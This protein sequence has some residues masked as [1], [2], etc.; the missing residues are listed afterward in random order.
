[1]KPLRRSALREIR[2][3]LGRYLAIFAIVALGVG[4]F[5]GLRVCRDAMIKTGDDYLS[6]QRM[7]DYRLIS[8]LGFSREDPSAFEALEGVV[9]AEGSVVKDALF[10]IGGAPVGVLKAHSLPERLNL[11]SLVEGRMPE[12]PGE[13][14]ADAK[15]F[16][17][18]AVGTV[19][20]LSPDNDEDTLDMFAGREYTIV[21]IGNSPLY[22]NFERGGTSLGSGTVAGFVYLPLEGFD[23]DYFTE[24]CV[25]CDA[26]GAIYSDVYSQTVAAYEDAVAD[27]GEERAQARYGKIVSDAESEL[28]EGQAEYDEGLSEYLE[29]R[30]DAE[31]ELGEALDKLVDGEGEIAENEQKLAD[32][33]AELEDAR[34]EL[35]SGK[36]ELSSSQQ[37][38]EGAER[39]A[40]AQLDQARAELE[41]NLSAAQDGMLQIEESGV[42]EQ[43]ALL[44]E[45]EVAL[46]AGIQAL[47]DARA[48]ILGAGDAFRDG[49]AQAQA[50]IDALTAQRDSA[51]AEPQSQRDTAAGELAAFE[52]ELSG[53]APGDDARIA[54]LEELLSW[55]RGEKARIEG[56]ISSAE[57]DFLARI[58][59]A[60]AEKAALEAGVSQA[61][62]NIESLKSA[63]DEAVGALEGEL[64]SVNSE[65][66]GAESELSGLDP[67]ADAGRIAELQ[68]RVSALSSRKSAL[69]GQISAVKSDYEARIA[70]AEAER[71]ALEGQVSQAAAGVESLQSERDGA[72]GAL[73]SELSGVEGEIA[74]AEG[75]LS[76]LSPSPD[77]GRFAEL[78][79]Q[80]S[81]K[82]QQLDTLDAQIAAIRTEYDARISEAE[83]AK[84]G[85]ES[86]LAEHEAALDANLGGIDAELLVLTGQLAQ[87][88]DGLSQ[89]E[90]GGYVAQ[91]AELRDA[92]PQIEAGLAEVASQ[93]AAAESQFAAAWREL[94]N[95]RAE[96]ADALVQIQDAEQELEDG[97]AQLEDARAELSDGYTEYA[98]AKAE[99]DAEFADAER[100]LEDA[101][102]ELQDAREKIDEIE[103]PDV[104]AL[105]RTANVGYM[106]FESDAQIVEGISE[107]FPLFF[108]MVAALVCMTTMTR[109]VDE[110]RTQIG[111]L[112]ALGYSPGAIMWKYVFYSGSAATLGS[113]VGFFAGSA[114]F[115]KVIWMAYGIMYGFSE[116]KL[117]YDWGLGAASLMAALLC[118]VGATWFSVRRD[119]ALTPAELIR[120]QAPKAG[121]RIFLEYVRPVWRRLK[122]LQKV[123]L[124]NIF[125]YKKRLAMMI[126]G[127]GGCTA[128]LV[129]GLG[130]RDSISDVVNYQYEEITRY[131]IAVEFIQAQDA[132]GRAAFLEESGAECLFV[133]EG[134]ADA[135]L[136][137]V[138]KSVNLISTDAGDISQFVDLHAGEERVALPGSNEAVISRGLKELTGADVGS[139]ITVRDGEMKEMR[140][141]VSGV[142]D[143]YV[144][145]YVYV[146][147]DT[148]L[149]QWGYAPDVKTA[150]VNVPEGADLHEMAARIAGLGD[151]G[152][153]SVNLDTQKRIGGMMENLNYI[154]MLIVF[155]AGALAFIVLYNLTN[156]NITERT[157]EIATIKVLGFF[158]KEAASYV[159]SE[160]LLLCMMS[161]LAGLP[162]GKWLHAFVMSQIRI[163]MMHFDVRVAAPSYLLAIA[164]TFA[165]AGMVNFALRFKL[166]RIN[167]AESLKTA[168]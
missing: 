41:G 1:M 97:R 133:H 59:G 16:G 146:R 9:E 158:P 87:V 64:S 85:L 23:C 101:Q 37:R 75:E 137:G 105:D 36:R 135:S 90:S 103:E 98:D 52:S 19:L 142:F 134:T 78:R 55:L 46:E 127:I 150:Y 60:E 113:L 43:Y 50:G 155:S 20:E 68:D 109:M 15:C 73:Q 148:C 162:L 30:A 42:L 49:I 129:T 89:I 95:G 35:S 12:K 119:L 163:D 115:P 126:I 94:R 76:G 54:E 48:Q 157:R 100:E 69:E 130:I 138:S 80:I 11:I 21:G 45:S 108:F 13:L 152:N 32:G 151:V 141:I 66:S 91:Y 167:M 111:V 128:L 99:A 34:G 2:K 14:V 40:Y 67:E 161:A 82:R 10:E 118:S 165:F 96:L 58:S 114:L 102:R 77:A 51:L 7:F 106:C 110:Q 57:A 132:E 156:I 17:S 56:E 24:I 159:F 140:L 79:A 47:D 3:S 5:S 81:A 38:L 117:V 116:L 139:E 27:S 4:F 72:L 84:G 25:R 65:I 26:P 29:K 136:N 121:K 123:S 70:D 112:K 61:A 120:P 8:T 160:N 53:L 63:R 92:I 18:E 71:A 28:A 93:R 22:L 104:Y 39:D 153:V 33:E 144:F 107:V 168:E 164:L 166:E 122:F 88:Q 147:E 154:V 83:A 124:R 74:A 86:Q 131:D 145:N 149:A 62:S 6:R 143:N 31:R 44:G 125:R